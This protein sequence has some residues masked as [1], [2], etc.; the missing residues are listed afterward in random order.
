MI[1][2]IATLYVQPD[3]TSEFETR[4]LELVRQVKANEPDAQMYQLV[5]SR[6]EAGV[7]KVMEL[8]T[9]QAALDRHFQTEYFRAFGGEAR[10]FM[11]GEPKIERLDTV[12]A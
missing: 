6:E 5:K 4:F 1:A 8:Y 11:A 9:D 7:Y 12:G 10:G 2:I 3:K